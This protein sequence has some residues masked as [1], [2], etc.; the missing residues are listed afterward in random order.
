MGDS[1]PVASG[2]RPSPASSA[3][4]TARAVLAESSS[5]STSAVR[6]GLP[7]VY[8]GSDK[9]KGP[10]RDPPVVGNAARAPGGAQAAKAAAAAGVAGGAGGVAGPGGVVR[11]PT[12]NAILVNVCQKG[13]PVLTH[14]RNVPWE[15]GDIVPDY[16]VGAT[17]GLLYLQLKYH[18]LHPEYIHGRIEKLGQAYSLRLMLVHCDVDNHAAAIKELTK[19]CIINNFTMIVA[20][21]ADECARYLEIYKA[22]ERKPPD[23]IKERVD[24]DYMSQLTSVLTSIKSVN[25]TDVVTLASTYGSFKNIASADQ[26]SLILLPGVGEKKA[27][28]LREAMTGSFIIGG[29]RKKKKG[30]AEAIGELG[31]QQLN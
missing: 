15:F 10:A 6:P 27:K 18:L 13:N 8:P 5:P 21:S 9:G 22:Y 29:S 24:T 3:F 23:V 30:L 28:R 7:I 20:W 19:V 25:K 12:L 2:S 26:S 1:R 11:R 16:Q 31:G 4:T 17:T 14:I